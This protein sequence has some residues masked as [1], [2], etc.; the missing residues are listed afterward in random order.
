LVSGLITGIAA[1]HYYYMRDFY[2]QTGTSPT[3][4]RYVD[5]T[6]TVPL[7]CVEFYLLTKPFGAKTLPAKFVDDI[8]PN[9]DD[10]SVLFSVVDK[11]KEFKI[12]KFP[13]AFHLGNLFLLTKSLPVSV[14]KPK[15]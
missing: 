12:L 10:V 3:A 14:F 7:M 2:L 5:W 4:F 9:V 11:D 8:V 6:L 1:V 13:L 15:L